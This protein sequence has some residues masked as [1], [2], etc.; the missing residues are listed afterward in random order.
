MF[1]KLVCSTSVISILAMNS[2]FPMMESEEFVDD[3]STQSS[4]PLSK[5]PSFESFPE[6][7]KL[8]KEKKKVK[9]LKPFILHKLFEEE[10]DPQKKLELLLMYPETEYGHKLRIVDGFGLANN[11]ETPKE[12][13]LK[14]IM[15]AISLTKKDVKLAFSPID[16]KLAFSQIAY[17]FIV[18]ESIPLKDRVWLLQH[19]Q[20]IP[21]YE[22]LGKLAEIL[23]PEYSAVRQD[24]RHVRLVELLQESTNSE[25]QQ[26][27]QD[28]L[29]KETNPL[30]HILTTSDTETLQ[31]MYKNTSDFNLKLPIVDKLHHRSINIS[32]QDPEIRNKEIAEMVQLAAKSSFG[33]ISDSKCPD[34]IKL[35]A[36]LKFPLD[37]YDSSMQQEILSIIPVLLGN[38]DLDLNMR[39]R[40]LSL[41]EVQMD[42]LPDD[43]VM[44]ALNLIEEITED[45]SEE[46]RDRVFTFLQ[47]H[48]K[49]EHLDKIEHFILNKAETILNCLEGVKWFLLIIERCDQERRNKIIEKF[50]TLLRSAT[51]LEAKYLSFV[52]REVIKY[53]SDSKQTEPAEKV[54][55]Q[56]IT[57]PESEE[58]KTSEFHDYVLRA[59][60]GVF[61]Y[62]TNQIFKQKITDY[63]FEKA[64]YPLIV[65]EYDNESYDVS[66]SY[67]VLLL[68]SKDEEVFSKALELARSKFDLAG[69]P[70]YLTLP[71]KKGLVTI[72]K[73]LGKTK[74][75]PELHQ[76]FLNFLSP[77]FEKVIADEDSLSDKE[78]EAFDLTSE[79]GKL[80]VLNDENESHLR[81]P[82]IPNS[83]EE[84]TKLEEK[85]SDP[86][87]ADD[88]VDPIDIVKIYLASPNADQRNKAFTY[89]KQVLLGE[90]GDEDEEVDEDTLDEIVA[91]IVKTFGEEN[92]LSQEALQ[93]L[94][95]RQNGSNPK[96]SIAVYRELLAKVKDEVQHNPKIMTLADETSVTFNLKTL[97]TPRQLQKVSL[98]KHSEFMELT[99]NLVKEIEE[100]PEAQ[101]YVES[102]NL[103]IHPN[104]LL[105]SAA[106]HYFSL[107][108]DPE[109]AKAAP[110]RVSRISMQ[111]R[112]IVS[113]A[114]SLKDKPQG[115]STS[116]GLT[117]QSNLLLQLL[118]NVQAC[119][120]NRENGVDQTHR[121]IKGGIKNFSED[122]M[123]GERIQHVAREAMIED[124]RLMRENVL[125]GDGPV[126]VGLIFPEGKPKGVLIDQPPHQGKYLQNL[127]GGVT[128]L[129]F[130]GGKVSYDLDGWT[131]HENIRAISRQKALDTLY[132]YFTPEKIVKHYQ[133]RFNT[134][135]FKIGPSAQDRSG[136]LI[137][138]LFTVE[139]QRDPKHY[140]DE[141]LLWTPL[142][143]GKV[144]LKLGIFEEVKPSKSEVEDE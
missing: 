44:K 135:N 141:D 39:I 125:D 103:N 19:S 1:K 70:L 18:D 14:A 130:E 120:T 140:D 119:P 8:D 31:R 45:S 131:V 11:P 143:V 123:I 116:K 16:L 91:I 2:A 129:F 28:Y 128:G 138:S 96:S 41:K 27:A 49:Q 106:S 56:Y 109:V 92:L 87:D 4:S 80:E 122:D 51:T 107:L 93:I 134:R 88:E 21:G 43:V 112:E 144:L 79:K 89:F 36:I 75:A 7:D 108:L 48:L 63:L 98:V 121:E 133:D 111:L 90:Q 64:K 114:Q 136:G 95:D 67:L 101:A 126:S 3:K 62:S 50:D 23:N 59:C 24:N 82:N 84:N 20:D 26:K 47:E 78:T 22:I 15:N 124:L 34:R 117:P 58:T 13:R 32:S 94:A 100:I 105:K 81:L 35:E 42:N 6:Q 40:L 55:W 46:N 139:E 30:V 61:T 118:I 71:D 74:K 97:M 54:L 65:I 38:R 66:Y 72:C 69:S 110:T 9:V 68:K 102:L 142:L 37:L 25:L 132:E 113:Y 73:I 83:R 85:T 115:P 60:A 12:I 52:A 104:F 137:N 17:H 77:L 99:E 86:H 5:S 76:Q 57:S 33:L 53:S 29:S 10:T 127:L